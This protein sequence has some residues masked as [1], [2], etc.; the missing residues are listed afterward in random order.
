M[1]ITVEQYQQLSENY[2]ATRNLMSEED[3]KI[4]KEKLN[5]IRKELAFDAC[6]KTWKEGKTINCNDFI[7]ICDR[8]GV[9]IS[10]SQAKWILSDLVE[11]GSQSYSCMPKTVGKRK[12]NILQTLCSNL[13][14]V[15]QDKNL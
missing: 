5:L 8:L 2:I 4:M 7:I 9:I 6:I 14:R 10:D 11:I 12:E 1:K 13:S 15:I 3:Q